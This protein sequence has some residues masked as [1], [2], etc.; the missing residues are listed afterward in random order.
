LSHRTAQE[1]QDFDLTT[2]NFSNHPATNDRAGNIDMGENGYPV[3][4]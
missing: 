1:Q 3:S 2:A 4:G